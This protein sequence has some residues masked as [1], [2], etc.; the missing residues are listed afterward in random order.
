MCLCGKTKSGLQLQKWIAIALK[1]ILFVVIL[2]STKA[3][4]RTSN[5]LKITLPHGGR[6]I[7]RYL[8]TVSGKGILAF[9]GVP[10]AKPPVKE[11]RFKVPVPFGGWLGDRMAITDAPLC[12]QRDPYR[13]DESISGV[14]DCLYL[15]VYVPER[16]R[17]HLLSSNKTNAI[18]FPVMVFFH[19]G[20][21]QCGSGT[22]SFYGPDFLL[23][24]DVIYIGANFRLGPLGFLSSEEAECPGNNGLKDQNLVLRWVHENIAS[25]GG[26]PHLVTIFGESA[27]GASGTYHMMSPLSQ[28]L[29][30]RVISQSGVNLDAWAQPAHPGVARSRFI[31][32]VTMLNCSQGNDS[33]DI[34]K[35]D[36]LRRV[37]A[38][39]ITRKFY[40]FYLW[41]TDPMIP[42]PPVVEPD[43]PGAFLTKHPRDEYEPHAIGL[44]WMTG[45]TLDEG[46]LK[47]LI[48][49]PE[50]RKSL[51]DHWERAL[52]ISLYYDHHEPE[53]KRQITTKINNYYFKNQKLV[54][55]MRRNCN[56][57][58]LLQKKFQVSKQ[59]YLLMMNSRY[60]VLLQKCGL[61]LLALV[62]QLL[63]RKL[64]ILFH[65]GCLLYNFLCSIYELEV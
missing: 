59:L 9:L 52:P 12:T 4:A 20:G 37:S 15:N 22:R 7:G 6:L 46:A 17:S 28:G 58:S 49:V 23:E 55:V 5:Q 53:K 51:N 8:N 48:N 16:P 24:H 29:F 21:W 38:E 10:Y 63:W 34:Q 56:I 60:D 32:L 64:K 19:G 31:Q 30:H 45:L 44:P 54:F 14:E 18:S 57:F 62:I 36:C 33:N 11:L 40:D 13:R 50:L 2:T 27:G 41:D 25:F 47:T 43:I 65:C 39:D 35:L 61:I 3:M 26:D 42:F 1:L